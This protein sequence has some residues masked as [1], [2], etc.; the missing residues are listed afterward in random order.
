MS[1]VSGDVFDLA[2]KWGGGPESVMQQPCN[3]H[4]SQ[5]GY[6]ET[7]TKNSAGR[8]AINHRRFS[9][10]TESH[11]KKEAAAVTAALQMASSTAVPMIMSYE[12]DA[13]EAAASAAA[14]VAAV[15]ASVASESTTRTSRPRRL[16][17]QLAGE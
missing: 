17:R 16:T 11:C 7:V 13:V 15:N 3:V 10:A 6:L 9:V 2:G 14:A 4:L 8:R 5:D 12:D 1:R